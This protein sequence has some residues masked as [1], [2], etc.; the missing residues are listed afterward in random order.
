[1]ETTFFSTGLGGGGGGGVAINYIP[2]SYLQLYNVIQ[3]YSL[4]NVQ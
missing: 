3:L 4:Y 2:M 1:M